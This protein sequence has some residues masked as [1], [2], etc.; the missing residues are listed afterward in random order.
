MITIEYV[1]EEEAMGKLKEMMPEGWPY[2]KDAWMDGMTEEELEQAMERVQVRELVDEEDAKDNP[3][4]TQVGGRHYK[5]MRIQPIEFIHAN[6]IPFI[7]GCG[8]KYLCR[9]RDKGGVEDLRKA[10]HLIEML[11]EMEEA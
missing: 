3:L 6:N 8:I 10:Q 11:I 1:S 4:D 5:D 2:S 7:E 9:W